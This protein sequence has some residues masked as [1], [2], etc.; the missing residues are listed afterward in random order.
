MAKSK[1]KYKVENFW[2]FKILNY[3]FR[4]R[5]LKLKK[6][7]IKI[8]M[9]ILLGFCNVQRVFVISVKRGAWK[10]RERLYYCNYKI[11]FTINCFVKFND[12]K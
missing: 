12:N 4:F 10:G 9:N 8:I 6:I 2:N 7:S 3:I 11:I 5:S 1:N